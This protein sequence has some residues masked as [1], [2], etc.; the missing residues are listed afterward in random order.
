MWSVCQCVFCFKQKT[1]Y[2][3]RPRDW[4]SDVCSSD[5]VL[6]HIG[7][8]HGEGRPVGASIYRKM[9]NGTYVAIPPA[10]NG[11]D[12]VGTDATEFYSDSLFPGDWN[13][14]GRIDLAG[15]AG[16]NLPGSDK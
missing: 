6:N 3:I 4:S 15:S 5:L 10:Q 7:Y 16:A 12:L 14:D 11:V 1:A 2:E 8:G 9:P 13:D